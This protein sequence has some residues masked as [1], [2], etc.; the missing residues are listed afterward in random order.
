MYRS[1]GKDYHTNFHSRIHLL[2]GVNCEVLW[3]VYWGGQKTSSFPGGAKITIM[4]QNKNL[5]A[6]KAYS[7]YVS[8]SYKKIYI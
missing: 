6:V 8:I 7:D 5:W 3:G 2:V 1:I 4:K